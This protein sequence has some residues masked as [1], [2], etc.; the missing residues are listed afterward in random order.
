[1]KVCQDAGCSQT[2]WRGYCVDWTSWMCDRKNVSREKGRKENRCRLM[3][4]MG[5]DE[6]L[7]GGLKY[8]FMQG[9]FTVNTQQSGYKCKVQEFT[10][11]RFIHRKVHT[12]CFRHH[13]T[14]V[15]NLL[16]HPLNI[17]H[18]SLCFSFS[19]CLSISLLF[20]FQDVFQAT[21]LSIWADR[22]RGNHGNQQTANGGWR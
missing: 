20:F 1:M 9:S 11:A 15:V 12:L 8:V 6:F 16:Y 18:S 7:L 5:F 17:A 4:W 22:W 13:I 19:L 21:S 14:P 2:D 10:G 3:S